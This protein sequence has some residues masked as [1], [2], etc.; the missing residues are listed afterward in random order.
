MGE[1]IAAV[2]VTFNRA[3]LL[4]E[5]LDALLAQ[6]R[7]VDAIILIDKAIKDGKVFK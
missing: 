5:C 3:S 1:S 7:P 2:V 6:T 4:L